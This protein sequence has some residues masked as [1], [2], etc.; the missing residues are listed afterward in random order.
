MKILLL[1]NFHYRH[2][3]SAV[4]YFN[5]A[6][7]LRE[8][9]HEV[10]FFS[11]KRKGNLPSKQE[12]YFCDGADLTNTSLTA[13]F[14]GVKRYFY[15]NNAAKK[16]EELIQKEKPD[17]AH[18]H[19][20]LGGLTMSVMDVLKKYNIP[21]VHTVHEYRMVCPAYTFKDGKDKVCEDCGGG[22]FWN[23]LIKK[24]SKNNLILSGLMAAEMY[25]RNKCHHPAN[26]I[27]AFIFV[28]KFCKEI[29][30]KYDKRFINKHCY[31]LYNFRNSDII[32]HRDKSIDTYNNYYLYYG[33]LS[34]EKGLQTL[35]EAFKNLPHQKLK[36]VGTGPIEEELK[37]YCN[38][39]DLRNIDFLGYISGAELYDTIRKSKFVIVPSEWYENN[40]MTIV[41][42]YTLCV[43]VIGA[44]IGGITEIIKDEE[45]GFLFE[46]ASVKELTKVL[47][48]SCCLSEQEYKTM[49]VNAAAFSDI[50][51]DAEEHYKKLLDIYR[52]VVNDLK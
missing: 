11:Q 2:G 1:N 51:F 13:R 18:A 28:S 21:I 46:S 9:G 3:G 50:N 40:P 48:K 4:V 17:V 33:R 30:L 23:C 32:K 29:H 24:C 37:A 42:A 8:K 34:F 47:K 52:L 39:H 15:N 49:K 31:A 20:F 27:D 25:Y 5:T 45:T 16:L 19:I 7:L 41:E 12:R 6:D 26:S 22:Y 36:I 44:A 38:R 14:K 10:I 35:I 43:P